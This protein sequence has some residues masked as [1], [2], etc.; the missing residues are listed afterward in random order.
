MRLGMIYVAFFSVGIIGG[1][2]MAVSGG[3]NR[4][5]RTRA[6]ENN[7]DPSTVPK[8]ATL[9]DYI[10]DSARAYHVDP[11]VIGALIQVESAG[12]AAAINKRSDARGLGQ[13]I[14]PTRRALRLDNSEVFDPRTNVDATAY[15]YSRI[16]RQHK[17]DERKAIENYY[18][19]TKCIG[20]KSAEAYLQ[21]V[22][23]ARGVG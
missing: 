21:R 23:R 2:A 17:G 10:N 22:N 13:L 4:T 5:D 20:G 3:H 15:W 11:R 12:Q 7:A 19:G 16:L 1:G 18:C 8:P 14:R 9:K 6:R